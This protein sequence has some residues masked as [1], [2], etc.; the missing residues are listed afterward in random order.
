[1][2]TSDNGPTYN[3]IG[4]SD[5]DF[6]ESNKPFSGLKGSLHEGGIR[7]PLVVW[8]PGKIE[9]GS[10]SDHMGAFQDF[11][12]TIAEI[13]NNE[14]QH[15]IDGLS[16]YPTLFGRDEQLQHPHLYWEFPSYGGQVAVRMD[17]WKAIGKELKENP[18]NPLEL[19]DLE[20]D[21]GEQDNIAK[22]YPEILQQMDSIIKSSRTPSSFFP[23][24][25]LD[26]VNQ[27]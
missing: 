18:D 8:W 20:K 17:K 11:L 23:F 27:K 1:M 3:R 22:E 25:A 2:F 16:F 4:G 9:P 19:Y 15:D 24:P 26:S 5:S 7:V 13:A 12:P 10:V 6:F 14:Y 21:L